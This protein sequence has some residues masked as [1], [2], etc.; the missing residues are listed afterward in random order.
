MS[1]EE[2]ERFETDVL[3]RFAPC[4]GLSGL[5]DDTTR[6]DAGRTRSAGRGNPAHFRSSGSYTSRS[7]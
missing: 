1:A 4:A 5:A 2:L 6:G 3:S 7:R